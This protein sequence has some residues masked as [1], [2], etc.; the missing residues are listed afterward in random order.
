MTDYSR[1]IYNAI[2]RELSELVAKL[3]KDGV[4]YGEVDKQVNDF[5]KKSGLDKKLWQKMKKRFDKSKKTTSEY[6][7]KKIA[8][9]DDKTL[10]LGTSKEM[11]KMYLRTNH[12][13]AFLQGEFKKE[14]VRE[15]YR[16]IKNGDKV[17]TIQDRVAK[18]VSVN[19]SK[20][21]AIVNTAVAGYDNTIN[22]D[23]AKA[24]GVNKF[25]YSGATAERDFCRDRLGGVFTIS[26]LKAMNNGQGLPVETYLGGYNCR[27]FL[28]PVIDS[29]VLKGVT[30]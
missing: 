10:D 28:A 9:V 27:H 21:R 1:I 23:M 15:V 6:Y 30:T 26:E 16:G 4:P 25:K 7:K 18:R 13:F 19:S 11:A 24:V 22:K 5:L 3:V 20:A 14:I 12:Q 2:R 29:E 8:W 17:K